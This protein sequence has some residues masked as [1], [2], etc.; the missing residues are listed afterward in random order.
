MVAAWLAPRD[1]LEEGVNR[2]GELERLDRDVGYARA[3]RPR[4]EGEREEARRCAVADL[5]PT[6][7]AP[8]RDTVQEALPDEALPERPAR[9]NPTDDEPG[10][11]RL[12]K[13]TSRRCAPGVVTLRHVLAGRRRARAR[14]DT[15]ARRGATVG[16]PR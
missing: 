16:V 14:A 11:L 15:D 6:S 2:A 8:R 1:V 13:S 3:V 12:P 4:V 9:S 7:V 5:A 10:C